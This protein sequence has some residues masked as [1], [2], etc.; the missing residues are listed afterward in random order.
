LISHWKGLAVSAIL[1]FIVGSIMNANDPFFG[2]TTATDTFVL[3]FIALATQFIYARITKNKE[4]ELGMGEAMALNIIGLSISVGFSSGPHARLATALGA[5]LSGMGL[6]VA[7]SSK[8]A[9]PGVIGFLDE[10]V[11]MEALAFDLAQARQ[12]FG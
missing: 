6:V 8:D 7:V 2:Q 11:E 3:S 5:V 10:L 9:L 4:F 12:A 1:G